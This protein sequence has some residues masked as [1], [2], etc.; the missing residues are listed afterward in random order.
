MSNT[1]TK[2]CKNITSLVFL[3]FPIL[4]N[5]YTCIEVINLNFQPKAIDDINIDEYFDLLTL[6]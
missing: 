4:T 6:G 2:N 3:R 1:N 5:T